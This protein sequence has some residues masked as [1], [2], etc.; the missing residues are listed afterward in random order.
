MNWLRT[1]AVT[2]AAMVALVAITAGTATAGVPTDQLRGAVDRVL[3]TLDD[4]SLKG[5]GKLAAAAKVE[6]SKEDN[7]VQVENY[8]LEPVR[9]TDVTVVG[10]TKK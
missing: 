3:K 7:T 5:Q 8:G 10:P 6:Y 1:K 4:P 9:L 2:L